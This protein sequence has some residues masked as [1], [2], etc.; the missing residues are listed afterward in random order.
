MKH[1]ILTGG[2]GY[3][4]SNTAV[5]LLEMNYIVHIMDNLQNANMSVF[6][7]I[8]DILPHKKSNLFF[9]FVDLRDYETLFQEFEKIE[10]VDAVIHFAGLKAVKESVENP[11]LYYENNLISTIHL[12]KVMKIFNS[13]T[14]IFSSSATVYGNA[15]LPL[16]ETSQ[17]GIGVK[18]PYG[19]S[20]FMMEEILKDEFNT[21]FPWKIGILRYF[22]P[23][24]AS[25]MIGENPK[26]I[27]N[28][29]MSYV[30][31]VCKGEY[32]FV[33]VFGNDHDT[34]DGTCVRDYIHITDLVKGYLATLDF[35]LKQSKTLEIF[36]LGTGKGLSVLE[37]IE[38]MKDVSGKDVKIKIEK[39]R[40]GDLPIIVT[41]PA[42]ANRVLNWFSENTHKD[43]CRDLWNLY[44]NPV[45]SM[46]ENMR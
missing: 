9:H 24:G 46:R 40:D 12:L 23:V 3:I 33:T 10:F 4:G 45:F 5:K 19:K 21:N 25:G 44:E 39:R 13:S 2:L 22:K 18:S 43:M 35:L 34:K 7:D 38:H 6:Q 26:D 27:S 32:P 16:T 1:I 14:L 11:L 28:N 20:K 30:A 29:L 37:M 41:S 36:N 42:K 31:K 8:L 17:T 15:Q